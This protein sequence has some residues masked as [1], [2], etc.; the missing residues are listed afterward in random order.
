MLGVDDGFLEDARAVALELRADEFG[1]VAG[2]VKAISRAMNRRKSAARRH[3]I[4]H[5]LLLLRCDARD[6]G[7]N[8]QTVKA[9]EV[10][11]I[12]IRHSFGI[13]HFDVALGECGLQ[14]GIERSRAMMTFVAE[15]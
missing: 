14:D 11:G 9:G 12:Q 13:N 3:E 6:V 2:I 1:V 10:R 4:E 5:R 8:E 7:V 15:K